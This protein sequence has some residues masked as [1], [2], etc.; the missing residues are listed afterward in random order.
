[1]LVEMVRSHKK[2]YDMFDAVSQ[3]D[4]WLMALYLALAM[5]GAWA[6]GWWGGRRMV[7]CPNKQAEFKLDDANLA[8]LG[9]L[10]AFTFAM[11]IGK[12][13]QRRA[14]VIADT[15]AIG[16]FYTCASFIEEPERAKLTALIRE[17]VELRLD[18]TRQV[19]AG[20]EESTFEDVLRRVQQ[21]LSRMT[22]LVG[23][24]LHKGTP[25]AVP[26]TNTLNEVTSM[27]TARPGSGQR[28]V[29]IKYR[30]AVVHRCHCD[31]PV[32]RASARRIRCVPV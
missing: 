18:L 8:L 31:S 22:D 6:A 10:I 5:I 16:D 1:M 28:S 25:I 15:N 7:S 24:A 27:N 9:L 30:A 23:D 2:E 3:I 26:L 14:M 12:H 20:I 4:A 32:D 11:S 21:M 29:T 13:D 17:Y 19:Q